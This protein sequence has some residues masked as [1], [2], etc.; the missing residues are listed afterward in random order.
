MTRCLIAAMSCLVLAVGCSGPEEESDLD[1]KAGA[2]VATKL[3]VM[4][5][6]RMVQERDFPPMR[7][8]CVTEIAEN[9]F[10][11]SG[12]V[13]MPGQRKLFRATIRYEPAEKKYV[14]ERCTIE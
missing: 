13:D 4:K 11:V 8:E 6:D 12:A 3:S 5:L 9:R 10:Q 7:E 1:R 2:W 14:C